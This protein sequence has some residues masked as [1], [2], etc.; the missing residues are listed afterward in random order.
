MST[1]IYVETTVPSFYSETRTDLE[2]QA[3]RKWTRDWWSSPK[4]DQRL[5]TSAVVFEELERIPDAERR[6]ESLGMIQSLE[7]FDFTHEIAE[8]V[9]VYLRHKLMPTETRGDAHHLA[10]ASF[11]ECDML[12]TWNCRHIANPNKVP[13]IRR[14]N[15][16]LGL[17]TPLLVTPLELLGKDGYEAE[18]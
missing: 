18:A 17:V 11:Y 5:V 8:I 4:E 13:H 3:R 16:L 6:S 2:T 1:L 9:Q 10:L 12:V 7:R 15:A 14:V